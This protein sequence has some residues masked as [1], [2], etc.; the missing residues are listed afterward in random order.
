MK[1]FIIPAFLLLFGFTSAQ[2][3]QVVQVSDEILKSIEVDIWIPFMEA[4]N[5]SDSEKLKSIHS[6]NII[7][8]SL[9]QNQI[10][11]G[12][13]YLERFGNFVEGTKERGGQIGIAFAILSTALDETEQLAH[14]SGYY[15][16]SSKNP[17]DEEL[18][19]RGYGQFDVGLKQENGV[20]K[21]WLD[22]DK[23]IQLSNEEFDAQE[24]VY[25][26]K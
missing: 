5:E 25:K 23:R 19:I 17:E 13:A 20:W 4:Y 14:Q 1:Y 24:I 7:R 21:I 16:F 6:Q 12:E 18:V 9:D 8:V 22:S 11:T 26:L 3:G 2:K 15:R 10:Q